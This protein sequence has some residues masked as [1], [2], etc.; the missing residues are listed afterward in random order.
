M[1]TDVDHKV[2]SQYNT[3]P[4]V[5]KLTFPLQSELWWLSGG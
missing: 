5:R 3:A 1:S 2:L 4:R